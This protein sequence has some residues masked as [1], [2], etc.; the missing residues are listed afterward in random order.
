MSDGAFATLFHPLYAGYFPMQFFYIVATLLAPSTDHSAQ[1]VNINLDDYQWKNRIVIVIS[2][3]ERYR[4]YKQFMEEWKDK[5]EGVA[6]RD[7]LLIEVFEIG[8][9]RMGKVR[10]SRQA[11]ETIR[12][13]FEVEAVN[14]LVILIGKDGK[15]KTQNRLVTVEQLFNLIDAMPMRQEEM[16]QP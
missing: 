4:R 3:N 15:V 13:R 7:L 6:N 16:K 5:A 14:Y 2:P 11:E 1:P 9:S 12:K 8:N 10:L